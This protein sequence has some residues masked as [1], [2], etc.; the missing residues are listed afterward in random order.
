MKKYVFLFLLSILA[1]NASSYAQAVDDR[2][3]IPVAVTLNSIL[4]LNVKSGGNI[5]FKFNTLEQYQTGIGNTSEY[6]TQISVASSV[7]WQLTLG[8]EDGYLIKTDTVSVD[9]GAQDMDLD[10]IGFTVDDD[11]SS[12]TSTNN[13]T[14]VTDLDQITSA[15]PIL[16]NGGGTGNAGSAHENSFT[17][18]WECATGTSPVLGPLLGSNLT[19]GRYATNVFLILEPDTP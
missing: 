6:D 7:N 19:G 4:R 18:H 14:S 13:A 16:E 3:V 12:N 1:Y 8:A 10:Y 9:A 2:A 17:I 5:E 11:N 15:S